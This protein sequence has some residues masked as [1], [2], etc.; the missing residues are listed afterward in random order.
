MT[1][2]MVIIQCYLQGIQDHF[3][4]HHVHHPLSRSKDQRVH[5]YSAS[6]VL[7]EELA[8]TVTQEM[9]KDRHQ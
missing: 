1:G 2:V 3:N 8:L 7:A 5:S 6:T 4:G 9:A